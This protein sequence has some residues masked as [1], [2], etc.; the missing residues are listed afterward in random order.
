MSSKDIWNLSRV[1]SSD[2]R[3]FYQK[4]I[5]SEFPNKNFP[6]TLGVS[7]DPKEF[8]TLIKKNTKENFS[9][10]NSKMKW[11]IRKTQNLEMFHWAHLSPKWEI[12]F[13]KLKTLT[14]RLSQDSK[15]ISANN[16]PSITYSVPRQTIS[17]F[18]A[19]KILA[20]IIHWSII[21]KW[22]I[23]FSLTTKNSISTF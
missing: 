3:I 19:K 13:P 23:W 11:S 4:K 14:T 10:K 16:N 21:S 20:R 5:L 7:L 8:L 6:Q 15:I 17:K 1:I 18:S 2:Q 12:C 9:A 22:R